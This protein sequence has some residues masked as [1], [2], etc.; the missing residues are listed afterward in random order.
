[1]AERRRQR[2]SGAATVGS[3]AAASAARGRQRQRS[4]GVGCSGGN[5]A[6][7]GSGVAGRHQRQRQ[8]GGGGGS[9]AL[10]AARW[11][12][13][14]RQQ[15][16]HPCHGAA[17]SAVN[18]SR[19]A[20][21]RSSV[22]LRTEGR[23]RIAGGIVIF[24]CGRHGV[25]F[26]QICHHHYYLPTAIGD[27]APLIARRLQSN[28]NTETTTLPYKRNSLRFPPRFL[29]RIVVISIHNHRFRPFQPEQH[30]KIS[31]KHTNIY[32]GIRE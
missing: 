12:R 22:P 8:S 29:L 30:D 3:L 28:K 1:L 10:V 11:Q 27:L 9:T 19:T 4:G 23:R 26:V 7:A 17:D 5:L 14:R 25:L 24:E 31:L 2:G 13:R 16:N 6:A 20:W 15:P 21:R 32:I 18:Y